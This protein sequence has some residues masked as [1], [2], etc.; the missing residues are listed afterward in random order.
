MVE[1]TDEKDTNIVDFFSSLERSLAR[2]APVSRIDAEH[3]GRPDAPAI[4]AR[5]DR[6]GIGEDEPAPLDFAFH[7]PTASDIYLVKIIAF[8]FAMAVTIVA[9]G[10]G[11]AAGILKLF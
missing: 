9:M 8:S 10:Y 2:P 4:K 1:K 7:G 6:A 3:P 11:I 5:Q